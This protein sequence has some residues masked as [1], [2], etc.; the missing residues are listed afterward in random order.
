VA[1]FGAFCSLVWCAY[2]L[3]EFKH[4]I[5]MNAHFR[6]LLF[7]LIYCFFPIALFM[8][9]VYGIGAGIL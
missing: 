7:S 8:L 1:E 9:L 3:I 6:I 4:K 2:A 5:D